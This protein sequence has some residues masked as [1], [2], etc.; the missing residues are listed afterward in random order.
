MILNT[1]AVL[2]VFVGVLQLILGLL[3]VRLAVPAWHASIRRT[4]PDSRSAVQDRVYL[5]LLLALLL[6]AVNLVSWP[7]LYLLLQSYVPEWP[8]VMCI[9]GVTRVGEGSLG[10]A[11]YLPGL[12]VM[13]Q[14]TKPALVFVGGAWFVLYK[15]NGRT[16]TGALL[17]RVLAI[18]IPLGML[19]MVDA[20]AELAYVGIPKKEEFPPAGCCTASGDAGDRLH[21]RALVDDAVRPWLTAAHFGITAGLIAALAILSRRSQAVPG[22]LTLGFLTL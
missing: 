14:F 15:L 7:L 6:L 21:P 11:Q 5:L 3:V 19:T 4:D 18:F 16:S 17:P 12:L 1:Y 22:S 8:G 20:A 9:Y 2:L 10:S 13:L